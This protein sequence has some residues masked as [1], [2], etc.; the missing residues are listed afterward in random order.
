MHVRWRRLSCCAH[1]IWR[2][3]Y[4][5]IMVLQLVAFTIVGDRRIAE[6]P[7]SRARKAAV[8]LHVGYGTSQSA[9]GSTSA[10]GIYDAPTSFLQAL[11]LLIT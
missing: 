11:T 4:G 10:I 5:R 6:F 1:R 7:R 3:S 2:G 8:R 9:R